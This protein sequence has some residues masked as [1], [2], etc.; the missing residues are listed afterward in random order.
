MTG[1]EKFNLAMKILE[2]QIASKSKLE[3]KE[4]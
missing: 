3:N 2:D 1:E 4:N